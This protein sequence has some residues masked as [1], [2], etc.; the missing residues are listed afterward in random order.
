MSPLGS[1]RTSSFLAGMIA[2]CL[3]AAPLHA[4]APRSKQSWVLYTPDAFARTETIV[5]KGKERKFY[6]ATPSRPIEFSVAGP[7][8]V[9]IVTRLLFTANMKGTQ[10]YTLNILED[11]LLGR[12]RQV[13]TYTFTAKKSRV[14]TL[15]GGSKVVPARGRT[16]TIHL[17]D[18]RHR[19]RLAFT[20]TQA[21]EVAV[22]LL[23]PKKQVGQ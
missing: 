19:L 7:A 3:A 21:A 17:P 18:G 16:V 13:S 22:R 11:G 10:R 20:D 15:A 4:A 2:L 12:E 8:D 1:L 14:S 6:V 23:I 5:T 9:R